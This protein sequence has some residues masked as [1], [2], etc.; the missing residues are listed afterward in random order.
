MM[1]RFTGTLLCILYC[2]LAQAQINRYV[3][4][5]WETQPHLQKSSA[6]KE[7]CTVLKY[8]VVRD[9]DRPV[10]EHSDLTH[11][12]TIYKRIRINTQAAADSL[13]QILIPLEPYETALK[14]DTRLI[15]PDNT[16]TVLTARRVYVKG[17]IET[18][19]L[20]PPDLKPG[21]ELEYDLTIGETDGYAGYEYMQSDIPCEQATFMLILRSN[22]LFRTRGSNGFPDVKDSVVAGGVHY[23]NATSYHI[24]ALLPGDLYYQNTWLQRTEF[25]MRE[26]YWQQPAKDQF[27]Q[28]V[29]LEQADYKKLR[30]EVDKWEFLKK[31]MP[32]PDL[33]YLIEQQIKSQYK[34][35]DGNADLFELSD[36]T[37]ILKTKVCNETGIVKLTASVY[38]LLGIKSQILFA[39][40]KESVPLDSNIINL[41]LANNILI[42]FPDLGQALAP[43]AP[44]TRFP[45]YPSAWAGTLAIRCRDTLINKK[46]EVL[47]DFFRTPVMD[48]T[49]NNIN[50]E[51]TLDINEKG[52]KDVKIKQTVGGAPCLNI[53]TIMSEVTDSNREEMYNSL[54][55]TG[56]IR[57][58]GLKHQVQNA[59][60]DLPVATAPFIIE[61]SFKTDSLN[62]GLLINGLVQQYVSMPPDHIPAEMAYPFYQESRITITL[63]AGYKLT[64]V[65]DYI[66]NIGG[67]SLGYKILCKQEDNKITIFAVK[68][69]KK[70]SY[71]GEEKRVFEKIIQ[72]DNDLK[73]QELHLSQ[74]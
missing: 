6:T 41:H 70:S 23:Y 51:A 71:D 26:S 1:K 12:R 45:Y 27:L 3:S 42:Y 74:N 40:S 53:K 19:R 31:R 66:K 59:G 17:S 73:A 25:A 55:P 57:V 33:I 7:A 52:V 14:M 36:L 11:Y 72:A 58:T 32:L 18:L 9:F 63:P 39:S 38:Y 22:M 2:L 13:Q 54:L 4:N 37:T 46:E 8:I 47:T 5:T 24:P 30:K 65:H 16:S 43:A 49:T 50:L 69:Y 20:T 60:W 64:N 21:C 61:S 44:N 10:T 67:T 48:Y 28:Y 15:Y 68:W 56:P 62:I 35:V 34:L 29:F